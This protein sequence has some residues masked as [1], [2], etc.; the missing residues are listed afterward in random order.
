MRE[1]KFGKL[2]LTWLLA[3]TMVLTL[4]PVSMLAMDAP[5]EAEDGEAVLTP[6]AGAEAGETA[7]PAEAAPMLLAT[8]AAADTPIAVPTD[9]LF[10][11]KANGVITGIDAD[12]L[13]ENK[14]KPLSVTIPAEI[15]GVAVTSIGQNAFNGKK[16]VAVDFSNATNLE[17]IDNQS[18][19]HSPVASVDLSNTQVTVIGK[20]AFGDC[21]SLET[22]I[23]SNT[24]TSLG[25]LDGASV[26]TDC[27]SLKVMRLENSPK[28][29]VFALPETLTYIGKN[30]F[31]NCFADGVDAKVIIPASVATLGEGA[32]YDEHIT[33]IIFEKTVD[34]WKN[35]DYSG[36]ANSAITPPSDC[37]RI[38]V[39]PDNKCFA[40]YS[41]QV[42]YGSKL[43]K[44]CT[45]PIKITFSPLGKQE[46]HLNHA[47][48]GWTYNP[49]T[50]L[51]D[52][53]NSYKLPDTNG[54]TSGNERPGYEYVGGWK[55]RSSYQVLNENEKLEAKDNPSDRATVSGEYKLANPTISYLV[56]GK[57]ENVDADQ[58][59]TVTIGDSKEHSIGIQ[60]DHPLLKENQGTDEDY[61]YFEYY[62][63]D[64][65]SLGDGKNTLNGPRST[66]E[67]KRFSAATSN[68][69]IQYV[70]GKHNTIP[71]AKTEHARYEG[72]SYEGYNDYYLVV[73][74]GYHVVN[75]KKADT[76]FYLSANNGIGAGNANATHG[77]HLL[78]VKV[79]EVRVITA[80]ADEHG[81][82]APAAGTITVPKGE[83]KTFTITPDSGYHIKDVLVDGKSVG[84]VS[85]YTFENVVDNHTIHA[86]FARK[87]TPTPSTP[88]VEIP[89]DDALGLNTTDHFAYIVGY[90]NGEVRPQN[91]I[92][93]AEVATIFFRL[94]T[95]DVRAENL[96]KTNRYSDVAATSWYNTAV[97]TLSSM[98]IIT[99]YPDGTFRPNAA[100]TRAEFAAI[101]ARFDNDGDKTA[102]KFSDIAT[103]WAKD[104]IS[105]AYN[106]GWITG[107]PDGTF[108]PQRD[109]TRAETMT[110]VN[111]V[112]NRQPETEDDLLPNMTVWTDNANPKAWYYLAVQEATNSHYYEFKTNSQYEK[113]TELRETRDWKAPEQ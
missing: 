62:W 69:K 32:F 20:F 75:G 99:G 2:F 106:N 97:S 36:Y 61:V 5:G 23:F 27:R 3:A 18:F 58:P 49:A 66:E 50:K 47:L 55:L 77:P 85:T 110:L 94:L 4:L 33:Q 39:L 13:A 63:F 45:Y 105:I 16:V 10:F 87:H 51:W 56:D 92:T 88:T 52:F 76:P 38:I 73:V 11:D 82:I 19:M 71:I 81:K 57:T 79:D 35:E 72:S 25:N 90:G 14:D 24:L 17:K 78:Q 30:T 26:F 74:F 53:N 95:D 60:V 103:H 44:I 100:I 12:W 46:Q 111:R 9:K 6:V 91:N 43:Q 59:F 1:K 54:A 102:A 65:V 21:K 64:E 29:V 40:A 108:G 104:E 22:F 37:D 70:D 42:G 89:D 68:V 15:G 107:Y 41:T 83:S 93:R 31:K 7:V 80:T 101:A 8:P 112:L 86:T 28:G 48:L 67:Q 109:I 84:A 96:T 113:W 98:G 34:P